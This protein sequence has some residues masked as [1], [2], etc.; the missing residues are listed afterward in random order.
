MREKFLKTT[1]FE[2]DLGINVD[3]ELKFLK[4]LK[5]KLITQIKY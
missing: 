3:Q 2:K 5:F 4:I 1:E